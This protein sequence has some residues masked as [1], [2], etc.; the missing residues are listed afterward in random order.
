MSDKIY[1]WCIYW[2]D[3]LKREYVKEYF[4]GYWNEFEY[5][6]TYNKYVDKI[7][8]PARQI[9]IFDDGYSMFDVW[10]R[11]VGDCQEISFQTYYE[12]YLKY[13]R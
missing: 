13:Q 4:R 3:K 6:M 11:Y 7:L 1:Y 8:K 12:N 9:D 10:H 5:Y 2:W